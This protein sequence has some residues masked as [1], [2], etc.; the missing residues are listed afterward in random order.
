MPGLLC[1]Y[2]RR[3]A[4]AQ[5]SGALSLNVFSFTLPALYG[6]LVKLTYTY[7]TT[8]AEVVNDGLPRAA[9]STIGDTTAP[10][11]HRLSLTYTL[12]LAQSILGLVMSIVI[13]IAARAFAK[14]FVPVEVRLG[15]ITYVRIS[16]FSALGSAIEAAVNASARTLDR[17]DIPLVL[18]SIKFA[19]NIV[20]DMLLISTFHVGRHTPSVNMQA[21]IQV[22]CN[23]TAAFSGLAYLLAVHRRRKQGNEE[24]YEEGERE[25]DEGGGRSTTPKPSIQALFKVLGPRGVPAFIESAVRNALYLWLIANITSLGITYATA[26]SVFNTIRWGLVMVPVS[27]LEATTLTFVG[28]KWGIWKRRFAGVTNV[29]LGSLLG[30]A[31]PA[32]KSI[33]IALVFEVPTCVFLSFW[34]ARPFAK[35]LSRNDDVAKVTAHMWKTIDWCYILYAVSTQLAAVLLA[36]RPKWYLWQSLA[37]NL[38]YVLPWAIVC[39]VKHLDESNAWTYHAL[40]FG[41][42]LVFSFFCVPIVLG[43]CA[44]D[45][46]TR[47]A[48]LEPVEQ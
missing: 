28:H 39:Q 20:L 22:T 44:R 18:S 6:T 29:S 34:G 25:G 43:L 41:G 35:F 36:T 2:K 15:S 26:W 9:W 4:R 46:K 13:L 1:F 21:G 11:T 45:L 48:H 16:A 7:I 38:L 23:L 3:W 10:Y 12:I 30:I 47:R 27:A 32:C 37:S 8:I 31:R 40:V 42:S 33:F 17:P 24:E 19:V 5:Y 14:S